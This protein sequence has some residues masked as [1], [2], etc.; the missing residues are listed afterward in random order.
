MNVLN[1]NVFPIFN[2]NEHIKHDTLTCVLAGI[3]DRLTTDSR[4]IYSEPSKEGETAGEG[5]EGEI[6]RWKEGR[7]LIAD[8]LLLPHIFIWLCTWGKGYDYAVY[9]FEHTYACSSSFSC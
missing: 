3:H 2:Q 1:V 6:K 5:G 4:R 9:S 8:R 7:Y